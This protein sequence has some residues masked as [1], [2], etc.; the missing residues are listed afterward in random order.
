M[1]CQILYLVSLFLLGGKIVGSFCVL[2]GVLAIA[3]PVPVI[4]NNFTYYYTLEQE[5]PEPLDEDYLETP[6]GNNRNIYSSL[7][8]IITEADAN[9]TSSEDDAKL[10]EKSFRLI[11]KVEKTKSNG[12]ARM[13]LSNNSRDEI[14]YQVESPV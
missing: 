9:I 4:V 3:F 1:L 5:S 2:V 6:L 10:K 12:S 11:R 8:S 7:A 14:E 13:L